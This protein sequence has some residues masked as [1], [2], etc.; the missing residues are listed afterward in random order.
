M[1]QLAR[2]LSEVARKL[3]QNARFIHIVRLAQPA[4]VCTRRTISEL[5]LMNLES[6][7]TYLWFN[8][9]PRLQSVDN[10][11]QSLNSMIWLRLECQMGS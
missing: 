4:D 7:N 10:Q 8:H 2:Y 9:H 5:H 1:R 11:H 3:Q 6:S